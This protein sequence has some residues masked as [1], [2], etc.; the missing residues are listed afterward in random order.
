[1]AVYVANPQTM[2]KPCPAGLHLAR[3]CDVIDRGIVETTFGDKHRIELRFQVVADGLRY[4][5]RRAFTASLHEKASLRR[6]LTTWGT[7]AD[8]LN[9]GNDLEVLLNR[10][11]RVMVVHQ[12]DAK[13]ATKTWANITALLPGDDSAP[14]VMG[15]SREPQT[16]SAAVPF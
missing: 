6:E 9:S 5:I 11:V 16:D 4:V 12:A 3:C 15:Y 13:D 7:L 2:S 8:V 1:M 14:A 10:P